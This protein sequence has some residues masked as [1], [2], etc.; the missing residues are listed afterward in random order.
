MPRLRRLD[1]LLLQLLQLLVLCWLRFLIRVC[2]LLLHI[3]L[4]LT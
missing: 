1:L 2:T 4:D 3:L